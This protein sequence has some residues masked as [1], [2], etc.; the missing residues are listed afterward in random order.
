MNLVTVLNY[1]IYCLLIGQKRPQRHA[2]C[3][4]ENMEIFWPRF[5]IAGSSE[6]NISKKKA[7]YIYNISFNRLT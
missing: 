4:R 5:L 3:V 7:R 2:H 1:F 6:L